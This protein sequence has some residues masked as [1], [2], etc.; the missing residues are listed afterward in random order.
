MSA[1]DSFIEKKDA[2]SRKIHELSEKGLSV[3]EIRDAIHDDMDDFY[4]SI[5]TEDFPEISAELDRQIVK[6]IPKSLWLK[7]FMLMMVGLDSP[8]LNP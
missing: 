6:N 4:K 1:Y 7:F 8:K 2:I 3:D 5:K